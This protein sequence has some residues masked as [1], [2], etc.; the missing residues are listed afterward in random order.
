MKIIG[1]T[2]PS[3]SGKGELC[4]ILEKFGIFCI[5][6]DRVYHQLLVPP[7][8]CLNELSSHFGSQILKADGTLDRAALAK[9]VFAPGA[10]S[11]LDA[12]NTITHKYVLGKAREM[13]AEFS[14]QGASAVIVDAPAL[15]E[16]GFDKECDFC[17]AVIANKAIRADRIMLRDGIS[18]D[19][20]EK[21]IN[22]QKNDSFYTERARIVIYN[23]SDTAELYKQ[24][25][26]IL[27]AL[28]E[29]ND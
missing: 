10:N 23:D 11:E 9:T 28:E 18:R 24:A 26:E 16:S 27:K 15:Y 22:A 6:T 21:R 3:G 2:G 12:L 8:D 17:V 29:K 5:D 1:L 25:L 14:K 20:A 19:A 13:I 4:S 7:S